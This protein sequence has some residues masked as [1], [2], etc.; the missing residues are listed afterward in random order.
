M[1]LLG[2]MDTIPDRKRT[3]LRFVNERENIR[4]KKERGDKRPWTSDPVLH[5]FSF[6]NV[7]RADD[8]V[9]QWI[10]DWVMNWRE[11]DRWFACAVARWFNEPSTLEKLP[12]RWD[13]V[14]YKKILQKMDENKVKIF[15]AAYIITGVVAG[16]GQK[17]YRA[18]VDSVLDPLS[19]ATI[20]PPSLLRFESAWR[21]LRLYPGQGSFMAGQIAFDWHTFGIT[22]FTDAK[23]W[24]PL[25]PG[26][27]KG[28]NIVFKGDPDAKKMS[29]EQGVAWMCELFELVNEMLPSTG[30]RLDLMDIQNCCCEFQK[31]V[32]GGSKMRYHQFDESEKFL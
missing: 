8:R 13:P 23:T 6:C 10:G 11:K 21:L 19:K 7:R 26:S 27:I 17:K 14:A 25:G 9:T 4:R 28:L 1:T 30:A 3:F 24:A 2:K 12:I 29:Q 32:R 31:Y 15:R 22:E 20:S 16:P 18:V 5:E